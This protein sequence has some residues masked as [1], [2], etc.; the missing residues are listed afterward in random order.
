MRRLLY[1]LVLVSVFFLL[2][3]CNKKNNSEI[4]ASEYK[5][6]SEKPNEISINPDSIVYQKGFKSYFIYDSTKRLSKIKGSVLGSHYG[7]FFDFTDSGNLLSYK[8]FINDTVHWYDIKYNSK[9]KVYLEE[10]SPFEDYFV[11]PFT[12]IDSV[13]KYTLHFV[14]Y[15]RD[16]LT[17]FIF[18]N[19]KFLKLNLIKSDFMPFLYET[20][21]SV[22]RKDGKLY[23]KTRAS[24]LKFDLPGLPSSKVFIDSVAVYSKFSQ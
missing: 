12:D 20:E 3:G 18:M 24:N 9:A 5:N 2:Y 16:S 17:A 22:R 21:V 6:A 1:C 11:K 23:I 19:N 14:S 13:L 8:Y 10:G 4:I 15:P 7:H